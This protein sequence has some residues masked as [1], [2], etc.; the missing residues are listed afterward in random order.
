MERVKHHYNNQSEY[1]QYQPL[2][3]DTNS[4]P[5]KQS[6]HYPPISVIIPAFNEE[7]SVKSQVEAVRKILDVSEINHEI[8][9]VDDGSQDRTAAEAMTGQA[10]VLQHTENRG[11]GA[12]IKTGIRAAKND[13][14][15][16]TD[17]DGTYPANQI[18]A[19][20]AQLENADMVV[21]ARI[22]EDV[23]IP[24]IR[25]PAKWVLRRLAARI[26]DQQIPDL[27]SGLRAFR[28][29][30]IQQY[31]PI[32]SNR[33]SFTTTSTLSLLADGYRVIY[34][35]INYYRRIGQSKITPWHFMDFT[36]LILRMAMLFQPLKIL[37]PLASIFGLL[38]LGKVLF[39]IVTIFPRH[40][41]WDLSL[42]YQ[43]A[44]ST[45]AVLLLLLGFQLLL[46]GM[47]ADGVVRRIGQHNTHQV[48]SYGVWGIE[49]PAQS[50]NKNT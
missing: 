38:G 31:F 6:A 26:A 8:I 4:I 45:S 28:R 22:G 42:L 15:V 44:I 37:M 43:P 34:H 33:F 7:K 1:F 11:Y 27:N 17:A 30:C 21:G 40:G 35:P 46:V 13:I 19:L 12:A 18:P 5:E 29:P 39:D 14:I 24:L 3:K 50:P 48:P 36:I 41:E 32:L 9:V 49:L 25:R 10:R 2:S 47:M 23:N 20:V 16:I